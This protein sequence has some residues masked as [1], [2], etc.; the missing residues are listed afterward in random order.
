M[1]TRNRAFQLHQEG[2]S[3]RL[4]PGLAADLVVCDRDLLD[5]PLK[6]VSRAES[7]LTMVDGRIVHRDPGI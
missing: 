5:A 6:K 2:L 7:R 1:H 4:V 3:G